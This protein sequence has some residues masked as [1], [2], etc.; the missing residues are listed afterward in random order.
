[1]NDQKSPTVKVEATYREKLC[2]RYDAGLFSKP[3]SLG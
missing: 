2:K 1:M 3:S